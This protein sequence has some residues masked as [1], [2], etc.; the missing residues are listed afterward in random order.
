[1]EA[2]PRGGGERSSRGRGL[3][4][5]RAEGHRAQGPGARSSGDRPGEVRDGQARG[6]KETEAALTIHQPGQKGGG[7]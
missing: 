7:A 2:R 1:M 3:G 5:E 6:E 4:Q